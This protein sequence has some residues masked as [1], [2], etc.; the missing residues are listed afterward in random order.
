MNANDTE[1]NDR[2]GNAVDFDGKSLIVGAYSAN[3][4][5]G[6]SGAAYVFARQ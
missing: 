3:A 1:E 2:F 6:D 5:K 4:P